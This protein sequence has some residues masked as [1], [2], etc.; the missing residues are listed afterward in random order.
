MPA[1]NV[2]SMR[3]AMGGAISDA[4]NFRKLESETDQLNTSRRISEIQAESQTP[5][6]F[7]QKLS[8][9]GFQEKALEVKSKLDADELAG[10][11]KQA[12]I[13]DLIGKSAD[14]VVDE[15][16][17]KSWRERMIQSGFMSEQDM[18][19]VYDDTTKAM[20]Q[21]LSL[22]AKE[23]IEFK[24][25]EKGLAI[26]ERKAGAAETQ[27]QAAVTRAEAARIKAQ[28]GGDKTTADERKLARLRKQGVPEDVAQAVTNG[29]LKI[30]KDAYSQ[31]ATIVDVAQGKVLGRLV[32]GKYQTE[33]RKKYNPG[34]GR[35]E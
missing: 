20:L 6:E 28:K 1:F 11:K 19:P 23:A 7:V 8:D 18:P 31:D 26:D 33:G 13:L 4:R 27:A 32:E 10:I 35:I 16:S 9:A 25:K 15:N 3:D 30:I 12:A 17:Y 14:Q 21:K 5:E 24:F 29:T 34:T 2:F 22:T